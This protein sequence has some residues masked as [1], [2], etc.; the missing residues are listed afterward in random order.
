[1]QRKM[2]REQA[3]SLGVVVSLGSW[4]LIIWAATAAFAEDRFTYWRHNES[5]MQLHTYGNSREFSYALPRAGMAKAGARMGDTLF[6]GEAVGDQYIGEATIFNPRCGKHN[7]RVAGPILRNG[8]KV[9]LKGNSP[10]FNRKCD[11]VGTRR[12]NWSFTLI[13]PTPMPKR[14]HGVYKLIS[15]KGRPSTK[16]NSCD[17][18]EVWDH[19]SNYPNTSIDDYLNIIR[20]DSTGV[21]GHEYVCGFISVNRRGRNRVKVLASCGAGGE[22]WV[23]KVDWTLRGSYLRKNGYTSRI[24]T[25]TDET[26]PGGPT[27]STA[28]LC[29]RGRWRQGE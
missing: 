20:V 27:S 10:R 28:R 17:A 7:F 15:Y 26:L 1:M 4:A 8:S 5:I 29:Y 19:S 2:K 9:V 23:E 21:R 14:F 22:S 3:W 24:G 25:Q 16:D 11:I 13:E 18:F 12:Q 6:S